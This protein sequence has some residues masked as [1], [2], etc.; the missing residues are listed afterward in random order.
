M[1]TVEA[2]VTE[3]ESESYCAAG[4]KDE[5]GDHESKNRGSL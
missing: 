1:T 4:F 5:E 2:G 3:K